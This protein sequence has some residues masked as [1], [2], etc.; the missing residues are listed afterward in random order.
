MDGLQEILIVIGANVQDAKQ[1]IYTRMLREKTNA[2]NAN[3]IIMDAEKLGWKST[4]KHNAL[5]H[6]FCGGGNKI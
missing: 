2:Q 4:G 3:L 5:A 6:R 1:C